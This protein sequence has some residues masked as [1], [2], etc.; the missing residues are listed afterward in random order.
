MLI[1]TPCRTLRWWH[2]STRDLICVSLVSKHFRDLAAAELYRDFQIVFPDED[3]PHFD[4]PVDSLAGGL[5]TF[6][7]SNYNYARHL[8]ILSFDTLHLGSKAELAYRPYLASQS[9][10]KFMNTLLLLT[11]RKAKVLESFSVT[12]DAGPISKPQRIKMHK[13]ASV[14]KEPPTLSG[15]RNLKSLAVLDIDSLDVVPELQKCVRNSAGTLSDLKLSFSDKLAFT[16]RKPST[17]QPVDSEDSDGEDEMIPLPVVLSPAQN[18]EASGTATAFRAQ[19]NR[20]TQE[21]VL[22]RILDVESYP[23]VPVVVETEKSKTN[24]GKP[25]QDL[26]ELMKT[27]AT[28]FMGELN[29]TTDVAA[30]QAVLDMIGSAAQ[31]YIEETKSNKEKEHEG[32]SASQDSA[33][34]TLP[35]TTDSTGSATQAPDAEASLYGNGSPAIKAKDVHQGA[36]P[37]DIDIEEPEEQLSIEPE[38][39]AVNDLSESELTESPALASATLVDSEPEDEDELT[40]PRVMYKSMTGELAMLETAIKALGTDIQRAR[41]NNP[42]VDP[43]TLVEAES[44]MVLLAQSIQEIQL[45]IR[46]RQA[47]IAVLKTPAIEADAESVRSHASGM[48]EYLRRTRGIALHSL[49]IYLIP[50]KASVL[51]RAVDLRCLRRLTLLNVGAQAPIWQVLLKENRE[52]PLPLR[53]IFTDNVSIMFL[54]FV[55]SL[56]EVHELFMLERGPRSKP[57]SFAPKTQVT[58]DHIRR[59]VLKKHLA[60]LRRLLIKNLAD[61]TWDVKEKAILLLCRQG[62]KLEELACNISIRAMHCLMQ[63]IAGLLS[64]RALHLVRLRSDDPCVWVMRETKRFLV[65]NISHYPHLK[66]EWLSIDEDDVVD[67]LVRRVPKL[68]RKEALL[69]QQFGNN[70]KGGSGESETVE[71]IN[72]CDVDGVRIFEKEVVAGRL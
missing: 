32:A 18:D 12:R 53:E 24:E 8:R 52:A 40:D 16:A 36:N 67:R 4:T 44:R 25:D 50:V 15:F 64:L 37:D 47:E 41:D 60:G 11:L 31:K 26:V 70:G 61:T 14:S 34:T 19:E 28:R 48:Q 27:T 17:D 68:E 55:A 1:K 29:G 65:D 56:E 35:P 5:D 43:M 6:A 39:P 23:P 54:N 58:I 69:G 30:S 57:E 7:T 72:F 13:R 46:T 49:S 20:K 51:S 38:E 62:S 22:G 71:G 9:C 66:L 59:L 2:C 21:S 42:L 3:N 63:N 45:K 33:S 10:G